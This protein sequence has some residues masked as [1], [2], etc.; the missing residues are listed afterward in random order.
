MQ[1]R[2]MILNSGAN[3]GVL[4]GE[5]GRQ[6]RNGINLLTEDKSDAAAKRCLLNPVASRID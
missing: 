2:T 3:L 4:S 6:N 1:L 5:G